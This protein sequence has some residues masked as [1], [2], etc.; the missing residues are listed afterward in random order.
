MINSLLVI[1]ILLGFTFSNKKCNSKL[2]KVYKIEKKSMYTHTQSIHT[3]TTLNHFTLSIF[4]FKSIHCFYSLIINI[5]I[6]ITAFI[7]IFHHSCKIFHPAD[8][9]SLILPFSYC[10]AFRQ[11]CCNDYLL[12]ISLFPLL[13]PQEILTTVGLLV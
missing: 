4:S 2:Q 12:A 5:S 9:R 7:T 11:Q 6:N 3:F 13:F 8:G 1:F 10:Q